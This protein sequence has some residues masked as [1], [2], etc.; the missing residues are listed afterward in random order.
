MNLSELKFEVKDFVKALGFIA[1]VGTMWLDLRD[2]IIEQQNKTNFLQYQI[3]EL[4]KENK[5]SAVLPKETE[6]TKR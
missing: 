4:K 2:K 6:I 3:T 5:L 1:M